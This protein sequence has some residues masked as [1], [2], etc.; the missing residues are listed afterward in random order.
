MSFLG[1][2]RDKMLQGKDALLTEISKY[3]NETFMEGVVAAAVLIAAADGN[4]SSEE[5]Q[6]LFGY[7]KH[8]EELKAF[9]SDDVI[10][11]FKKITDAYEF[12]PAIGKAEALKRVGRLKNKEEQ[13]RLVIHVAVAIANSDGVFDDNEK[14][15]LRVLCTELGLSASEFLD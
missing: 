8:A 11:V 9:S 10:A 6:K 15:A 1:G 3:R 7:V 2:L 5:K 4:I 13:A 12:D 14:Q